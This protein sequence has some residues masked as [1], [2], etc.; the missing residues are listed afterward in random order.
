MSLRGVYM[1][2]GVLIYVVFMV[3]FEDLMLFVLL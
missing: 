1:C 3:F 2:L